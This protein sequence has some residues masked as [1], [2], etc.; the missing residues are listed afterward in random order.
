M[1]VSPIN[2]VNCSKEILKHQ[3]FDIWHE[4]SEEIK[5]RLQK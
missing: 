5:H 4:I 1:A 3:E 2:A